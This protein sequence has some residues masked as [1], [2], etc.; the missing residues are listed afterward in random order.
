[1]KYLK[2]I[3]LVLTCI[4]VQGQEIDSVKSGDIAVFYEVYGNGE[5]IYLLAGGPGITPY[6][7]RTIAE[8]LS[9]NFQCVLIHQRGTG[10]TIIPVN[11]QTIQIEKYCSDIKSIKGKL[12]HKKI[13]MLGHSW[14]GM[15]SMHYS[16]KYPE[17]LNKIILVGSGG[18]NLNFSNYFGD[19]IN[20]ALSADDQ[21]T[22]QIL[23]ELFS[24]MFTNP[25][26]EKIEKELNYLLTEYI[27]ITS[28]G[29]MYD[30]TKANEVKLT[31]DDIDTRIHGLMFSSLEKEKWN[32]KSGLEKLKVRTLIIQGRQD[33]MD[34]ET[35]REINAAIKG[36]ELLIIEKSGHFPW[37]EKPTEFYKGVMDFLN[38]R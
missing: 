38:K 4:T 17:D 3:V 30:K 23:D 20:S 18:Y 31:L 11:D 26:K 12:K 14:G 19:N 24:Q 28:K 37:I 1:M 25:N 27:N 35:A 7:M 10:K 29:Y 34:L 32:I 16:T 21:K 22:V 33:P 8:E 2:T 15:L 9:K 6:G 5:P 13:T 36:S